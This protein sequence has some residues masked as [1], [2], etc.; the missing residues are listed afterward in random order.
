MTQPPAGLWR[1]LLRR[2][3]F[4]AFLALACLVGVSA[5]AAFLL[6]PAR[7]SASLPG[8]DSLGE[9]ATATIKANRDVDVLDP[10]ATARKREEAARSVWPVYDFDAT[11]GELLKVRV[12]QAFAEGRA[13][14]DEW[15][16]QTPGKVAHVQLDLAHAARRRTAEEQEVL[17]YLLERRDEFW[18]TLQAVVEDVDY[19][20]L[21]RTG[22]D[23]VVE[24]AAVRLSGLATQ[25]YA[26]AERELLAADRD[27]GI[28]V[29]P[30]AGQAPAG[31][32]RAVRDIDRIAGLA[33]LRSEADRLAQEQLVELPPPVRRAVT[34]IVKLA[35][36]PNLAYDDQETRRRQD[37]KRAAVKEG[38]LQIR[39]GD[40]IVR[41][42]DTITRTHLLV[43]RALRAAGSS[44]QDV[45]VRW[46]AALFAALVA[47]ALYVFARRNVRKFRLRTRDV[48]LLA[49]VLVLQLALVRGSVIGAEALRDLV[50]E[51]LRGPLVPAAAEALMA[52]VPLAAGS[53]LVRLLVTSE[54]ALVW[55]A[56]FAPLAG[57]LIGGSLQA[58]VLALI[59]GVVAADRVA[60]AATR[61]AVFR[62]G[63][64][65][66]AVNVLAVVALATLQAR[67]WTIELVATV[68]GVAVSGAL[69]VPLVVLVAAPILEALFGYVTDAELVQLANFNHR[70]LKDLIVQ[71][72][73]T[74]H[75]GIVIGTLVEAAAREI[76]ANPLLARV[77]AYYHDIGKGKNP[78][79]FGE[80]Q[81]GENRHD[82]LPPAVSAKLIRKH[83]EDG[84]ELARKSR[85][86]QP[87]VDFIEQHHGTR[88]V[89]YFFH[90]A[91]DEASR[92]SEPPPDETEYRYAGPKPQTRE[93]ALVMMAD[94]LVATSRTVS[95]GSL[96]AL[97]QLADRTIQQIAMDG[98]LDDC[99]LTMRD[100][101][102][103]SR[104]F[105]QTLFDLDSTRREAPL[106]TRASLHVL[107]P[108]PPVRA[109]GK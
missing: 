8:D 45:Q 88:L 13:A 61:G 103:I 101:E 3:N 1:R 100:L 50:R 15:Q 32:E 67:P 98:Q 82:A 80:N 109:A 63:A 5:S 59:G 86:P 42:G 38:F 34:Q 9:V 66:G 55:T 62:A 90:K 105:A 102:S 107:E 48:V 97:R 17:R 73:G 104:V 77:G 87:V 26:V 28:V 27:R 91:K 79:F 25:G 70:L 52:A 94:M 69:L 2:R 84:V 71:A 53:M 92:K 43:F 44:G 11:A 76:G 6:V 96:P 58:A 68:V 49:S 95:D 46:G 108:V 16:R 40:E 21:A 18:K 10:E 75:H 99:E 83:V 31:P 12:G 20:E 30:L 89:G 37:E 72:P 57:L 51:H 35:L 14:I 41:E 65:T 93:T 4:R 56:A 81:K 23:P 29:R 7:F 47:T 106:E 78:L 85:L 54:A 33:Q 36:R 24:R 19:F 39:R 74:Y 22:F 60:H 64:W